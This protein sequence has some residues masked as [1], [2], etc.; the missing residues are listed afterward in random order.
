M[1]EYMKKCNSR[2]SVFYLVIR[3]LSAMKFFARKGVANGPKC[4]KKC[5]WVEC[6]N[7]KP[8]TEIRLRLNRIVADGHNEIHSIT[9]FW[10]EI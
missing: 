1:P 10:D 6:I 5:G 8:K 7:L 3:K 4:Q 2:K 9:Q